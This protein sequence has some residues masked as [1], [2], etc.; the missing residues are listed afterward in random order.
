MTALPRETG[1]GQ[2][3]RS[4]IA[5]LRAAVRELAATLRWPSKL[6]WRI[7]R[8][9]LRSRRNSRT[10][11]LNT[12]I[13]TGGVAVGVT[14][15]IVVLGVM[16]GLRDDLQERILVA[17][18][19]LRILTFGSGLRV[20]DWQ[21]VLARVR[22]Q[23]GVVAASPEVISQAGITAGQDYGEGV[24]LLGFDPDTG[25]RS[26]TSLP[27]SITKGD[28]SF[29]TTKPGVDGGVL[30]GSRLA[31]RLSV[32]PGDIV[33]LVPV[34]Q[35]KVNPALG[36]AVPRFWK[37]E[38]TGLFDTGMFQY[39]N[40]FVVMSRQN[41]QRFTGL[42]DAVSGIAVRVADPERAPEIGVALEN[43]LGYPYRALDWQT[44]NS[45]LFSALQ[46]EKLAMGLI[47]FFIMV[48]A[49]FNI[50]GTL[51]MVV[52][53]KT[54]EIGILRAMGLT[55]TAVARVFLVQ[56]AVIG[57]VGTG[58]GLL[59]GLSLAYVVDRSGWVRI[60]PAIYFI[61]HLPVHIEWL[62]VG[63]VVLASLAIALVATVYPSRSAAAL[64]PVEAIRHE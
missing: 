27:Q 38:V 20:D 49:A 4:W 33:T 24:N 34:T 61:D 57:L 58:I 2:W 14:A 42:G 48:V 18:P 44:Q 51:T 43:Q 25:R 9:Y 28:L 62:D 39:D 59:L 26:V 10:A 13:S 5:R 63:V 41:A 6:E 56:G 11:S 23:P 30:L 40:Q 29:R 45:S 36:V 22:A 53:D 47:I 31:S 8:R 46:L 12:V 64:T 3:G 55:A 1:M 19:H 60:N 17:N 35:A 21:K 32:Y 7:A 52:T 50:V 15:L 16:N 54:K 37:F